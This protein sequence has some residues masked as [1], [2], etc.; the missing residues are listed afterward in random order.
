[1]HAHSIRKLLTFWLTFFPMQTLDLNSYRTAI[2]HSQKKK[3]LLILI[4]SK[5]TVVC[6]RS[7]RKFTFAQ[8]KWKIEME[9]ADGA[10]SR[11]C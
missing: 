2:I 8:V 9:T 7:A 4:R 10:T 5:S 11:L 1:M 6:E 3:T